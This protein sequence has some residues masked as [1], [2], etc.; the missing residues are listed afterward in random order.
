LQLK[1]MEITKLAEA[2]I[3]ARKASRQIIPIAE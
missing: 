3:E 1:R 2:E